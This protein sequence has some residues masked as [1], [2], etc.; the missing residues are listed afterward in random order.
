MLN[1]SGNYVASEGGSTRAGTLAALLFI[2]GWV[3][4]LAGLL[5]WIWLDWKWA[6]TGAVVGFGFWV[7]GGTLTRKK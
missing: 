4:L 6:A 7:I 2:I 3:F 1:S 5:A